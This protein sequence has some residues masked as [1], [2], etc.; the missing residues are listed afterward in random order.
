MPVYKIG[1]LVSPRP[2]P[3]LDPNEDNPDA[4]GLILEMRS[5][6]HVKPEA[7]ILWNDMIEVGPRWT[8]LESVKLL[9]QQACNGQPPVV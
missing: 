7:R 1:D 4:I 2:D 6:M 5:M 3:I 8:Y 9:E